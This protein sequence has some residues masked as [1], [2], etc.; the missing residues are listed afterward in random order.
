MTVVRA[1][2]EVDAYMS[3]IYVHDQLE[4][5]SAE[6]MTE[7]QQYSLAG[8]DLEADGGG[9]GPCGVWSASQGYVCRVVK[10]ARMSMARCPRL[11]Q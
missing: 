10:R 3:L 5:F 8:L 2:I 6:Q 4:G 11:S 1:A 7:L 9:I